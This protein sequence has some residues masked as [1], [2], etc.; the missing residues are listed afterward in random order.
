MLV[1]R[2]RLAAIA[3]LTLAARAQQAPT[4][5]LPNQANQLLTTTS[6]SSYTS[7]D[8]SPRHVTLQLHCTGTP[9]AILSVDSPDTFDVKSDTTTTLPVRLDDQPPQTFGWANLSL[10]R[11]LLYNLRDLLPA[12]HRLS[13]DLP[14]NSSLPQTLTFDLSNLS[15]AMRQNSCR[16]R[17]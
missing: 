12:H 10:H 9:S 13:I 3:L 8:G 2:R 1:T 4:W 6:S 7:A 11:I 15:A 5:S 14:L 17:L 16:H